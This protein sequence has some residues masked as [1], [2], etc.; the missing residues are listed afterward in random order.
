MAFDL[1]K[2]IESATEVAENSGGNYSGP[3]ILY[4]NVG[5]IQVRLLFNPASNSVMRVVR[6]HKMSESDKIVCAAQYKQE[7]PVCKTLDNIHSVT[8][9]D[10]WK[11]KSKF[12]GIALAQFVGCSVGYDWGNY[13]APAIGEVVLLMFPW[14]VYTQISDIIKRAGANANQLLTENDG[15]ILSIQRSVGADGKHSYRAEVDAFSGTFKSA[16]SQ[17]EFDKMLMKLDD[18][19]DMVAPREYT[20]EMAAKLRAASETLAARYLTGTEFAPAYPTGQAVSGANPTQPAQSQI[21]NNPAPQ[22]QQDTPPWEQQQASQTSQAP[23][24]PQV[25]QQMN[26]QQDNS[27]TPQCFGNL[28]FSSKDCLLCAHTASCDKAT[29]AKKGE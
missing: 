29:K 21:P 8:G 11:M 14:S 6:R 5:T 10:F 23:Q 9:R 22:G 20:V 1:S 28:D 15:K 27:G 19:N 24:I 16:N 17:E 12:Q 3:K 25:S 26:S 4:P 7:C 13:N 18:L 2:V